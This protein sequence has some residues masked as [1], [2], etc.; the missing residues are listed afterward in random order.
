MT[1]LNTRTQHCGDAVQHVVGVPA[2]SVDLFEQVLSAEN[3]R[4]AWQHEGPMAQF[5]NLGIQLAL[6][7]DYQ[8][9]GLYELRLGWI[10]SPLTEPPRAGPHGVVW[11]WR[12]KTSGYDLGIS[13][14][15]LRTFFK[16]TVNLA[17]HKS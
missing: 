8:S 9:P 4:S 1:H 17:C 16:S 5:E 12:R 14:S 11:G 10:T 15:I 3:M 13:N 7:N 2:F 6:S